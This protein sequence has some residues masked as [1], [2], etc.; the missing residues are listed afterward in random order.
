MPPLKAWLAEQSDE[1]RARAETI[2]LEHLASGV[3]SRNYVLVLG[4]RR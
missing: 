2:Y 1:V 4:T 3:L